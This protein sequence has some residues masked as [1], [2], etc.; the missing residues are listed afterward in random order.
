MVEAKTAVGAAEDTS[1]DVVKDDAAV[2]TEDMEPVTEEAI[3]EVEGEDQPEMMDAT[4]DDKIDLEDDDD[5][6]KQR[7]K[8]VEIEY[9]ADRDVTIYR[10]KNKRGTQG[11]EDWDDD[12]FDF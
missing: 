11:W 3:A 7:K 12:G 4:E 6:S 2:D 9:D 10:K 8:F 1:K 5:K